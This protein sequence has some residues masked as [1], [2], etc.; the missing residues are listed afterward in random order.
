MPFQESFTSEKLCVDE[1]LQPNIFK[2]HLK[3]KSNLR[4][5]R[6][7]TLRKKNTYAG[8]IFKIW[9]PAT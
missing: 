3:N 7:E 5:Q 2:T 9:Q 4:I 1:A 6:F 8:I